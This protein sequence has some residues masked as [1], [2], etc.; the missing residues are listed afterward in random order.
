MGLSFLGRQTIQAWRAAPPCPG[1]AGGWRVARISHRAEQASGRNS[2][3]TLL[4]E[5]EGAGE[6]AFPRFQPDFTAAAACAGPGG[7][8]RG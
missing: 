7:V 4:E 1:R 3:A 6:Q 5:F 8:V 2:E